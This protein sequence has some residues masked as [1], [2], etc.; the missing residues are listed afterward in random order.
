[1]AHQQVS[2][3][4]PNAGFVELIMR[5][6][7]MTMLAGALTLLAAC[8]RHESADAMLIDYQQ[9][10]SNVLDIEAPTPQSPP[11]IPR[12]PDRQE[13]LF[14]IAPTRLGM[15]DVYALRECQIISLVAERN[16]QLGK[17]ATA[18][19]HWL[20]ELE[21]WRRLRH[22]WNTPA[23]QR[24][25]GEDRT[26][27]RQ[28]L[29][30]KTEQ[31]PKA[32]W[33][34][35][36]DSSEWV[37][38]FSRVSTPLSPAE[39]ASLGDDLAALAYLRHM[40]LNQYN[41]AWTPESGRLEAHLQIL[42]QQPSTARLLRSLLLVTQRLDELSHSL[43]TRLA[44]RPVCY[45]GHPNPRAETLHNVFINYFIGE[46]Q[47]YLASLDRQSRAWLSAVDSLLDAYGV[48]RPSVTAYRLAWLSLD[49]PQAP[50]QQF[51]AATQR[52]VELWQR[53]WRSCGMMPGKKDPDGA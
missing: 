39:T 14:E 24:L 30:D 41:P 12:F 47:A 37:K 52:H 7:R 6:E 20:Y 22:C 15:L 25:D 38:N 21:L 42:R 3:T 46:V 27:L 28:L 35:L 31:L 26:Q 10:V 13:R 49:T 50:W 48:S 34:A 16:S 45:N 36:F 5:I 23:V 17:V 9:R 43:E 29:Q 51:H 19:Q 18:S 2:R 4:R 32:S 53:I 1:M 44:E 40:V 11:N 8:D 33:N